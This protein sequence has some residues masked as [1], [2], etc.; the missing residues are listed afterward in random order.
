MGFRIMIFS[1]SSLS[2][3]YMAIKTTLEK[4][5]RDGVT[6]V[7]KYLTPKRLFDVCGLQDSV[8]ID[9]SAGGQS[10]QGRARL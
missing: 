3:A 10:F 9:N 7:P 4:V 1:F 5:K 2:P 8:E 6:G